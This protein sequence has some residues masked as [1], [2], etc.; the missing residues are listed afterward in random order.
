MADDLSHMRRFEIA[1]N[2]SVVV[3]NF[4]SQIFD[5]NEFKTTGDITVQLGVGGAGSLEVQVFQSNN[6]ID[7]VKPVSG[8]QV[9]TA[10]TSGSGTDTDGKDLLPVDIFN[11]QQFF[12]RF[13]VTT[14]TITLSAN[15][16]MQ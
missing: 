7:F 4:D 8:F 6:G 15:L 9:T 2:K 14:D 13:V 3:G 16:S 10:F 1:K 5:F 11:S 12:L